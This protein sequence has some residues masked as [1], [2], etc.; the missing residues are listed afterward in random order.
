MTTTFV[1]DCGEAFEVGAAVSSAVAM[2]LSLRGIGR[3]TV[4]GRSTG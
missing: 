3:L 1:P 4:D 2:Q